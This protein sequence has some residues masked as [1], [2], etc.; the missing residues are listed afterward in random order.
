MRLTVG[1]K[2][3]WHI[4]SE[5]AHNFNS[6]VGDQQIFGDSRSQS[7]KWTFTDQRLTK[8]TRLCNEPV[9]EHANFLQAIRYLTKCHWNYWS[10]TCETNQSSHS[11]VVILLWLTARIGV[12]RRETTVMR[13]LTQWPQKY[14]VLFTWILLLSHIHYSYIAYNPVYCSCVQPWLDS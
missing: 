4:D 6:I 1:D 12:A 2:M 8:W 14:T 7:T 11:K 10:T 9:S 5:H 3:H 13:E